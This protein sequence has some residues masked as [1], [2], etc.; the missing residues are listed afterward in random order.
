LRFESCLFAVVSA[1]AKA[2]V[3][4]S[5]DPIKVVIMGY[6][7]DNI[8]MYIYGKLIQKLGYT[9]EFT[10]ADYLGQFAGL[11]TGD[12]HIGSPGWDHGEGDAEAADTG[13]CSTW[14]TWA[15]RSRRTGGTRFM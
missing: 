1:P 7:G 3:P 13:R 12:L 6:S 11:E 4:E 2:E 15:F 14:A 10:P 9:V 5:K 8:I